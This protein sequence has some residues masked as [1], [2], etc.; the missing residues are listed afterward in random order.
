MRRYLALQAVMRTGSFSRAADELGYTQSAM[1]QAIASLEQELGIRLLVRSRNGVRL[2]PDGEKLWPHIE[3]LIYRYE[4]LQEQAKEITGLG[5]GVIRIGTLSSI[6]VNWLPTIMQEFKKEYPGIDFII[7]QGNYDELEE[8]VR[9]G[10]V[11]FSFVSP[12]PKEGILVEELRRVKM[13]AV[14]PQD[15]PLAALEKVPLEKMTE[16]PFILVVLGEYSEPL[17]AFRE[18]GLKPDIRYTIEDDYTIMSMVEAGMGVSILSEMVL[19]RA[20]YNIALR[21]TDP[22]VMRTVCIGYR[23]PEMLSN[24]ARQMI[25]FIREKLGTFL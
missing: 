2:T 10:A 17:I 4:D 16:D 5:R 6:S 24:A 8:L 7:Q 11:D 20:N 15:H 22:P 25:R 14:L 23:S 12:E 9:T 1:S 21:E 19:Q 3:Q 13:L 18:K